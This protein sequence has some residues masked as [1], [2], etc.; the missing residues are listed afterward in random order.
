VAPPRLSVWIRFPAAGIDQVTS[1]ALVAHASARYL[2]GTTM[3]P[4][5]GVGERMAHRAFSTGIIEHTVSFHEKVDLDG[6]LLV[7]QESAYAGRGRAYG[8]GQVFDA[9]GA[10]LAS[11]SQE[12]LMRPFPEGHSVEGREAT[13]L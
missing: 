2:M 8:T 6:W 10:L 11:F 9:A 7:H 1:Q 3:L 12:A 4:H 5:S 13:V